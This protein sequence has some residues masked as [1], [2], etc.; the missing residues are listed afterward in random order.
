MKFRL[1]LP[2]FLFLALLAPHVLAQSDE[3]F[4][5]RSGL[6]W[7]KLQPGARGETVRAL[8][9]LLTSRGQKIKA[10]GTFGASTQSAVRA[11]QQK[12]KFTVDG[13][14]GAQTWQGL[15]VSLKRG[16]K[17][18]AVR[19]LQVLLRRN[20]EPVAID[21]VF[22]ASTRRALLRFQKGVGIIKEEGRTHDDAWCYLCGGHYDGE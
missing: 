22:G 2:L 10:D 18:D 20:D 8:Q 16:S 21:G 7:P 1:F 12:R 9:F 3:S 19:A 4:S 17:G 6:W 14:V 5:T 11:F 15:I 13:I